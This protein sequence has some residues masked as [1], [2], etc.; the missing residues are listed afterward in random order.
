MAGYTPIDIELGDFSRTTNNLPLNTTNKL[1]NR[2]AK[3]KNWRRSHPYE[4]IL[5]EEANRE[6]NSEQ[7]D[8]QEETYQ[9]NPPVDEGFEE[10][11][12]D[13]IRPEPGEITDTIID[14]GDTAGLL[15]GGGAAGAAATG[16]EGVSG[17]ATGIATAALG[18]GS[19][20]VGGGVAAILN[21]ARQGKGYTLPNSEFIGPGNPIPIGAARNSADQ[22]AKKH[23]AGY[24]DLEDEPPAKRTKTFH[25]AV[26]DLDNEAIA[27][28]EESYKKD[29]SINAKLGATG[30]GIKRKVEDALG[31]PL[32]PKKPSKCIFIETVFIFVAGCLVHLVNLLM[33]DQIGATCTEEKDCMLIGNTTKLV[34]AEVLFRFLFQKVINP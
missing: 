14:I 13:Q 26:A 25:E 15:E 19:A 27:D 3:W 34:L 18:V 8:V 22:A 20:I 7:W 31:F 23:D 33:R 1:R 21:K 17:L 16:L 32:Y 4:E 5:D 2:F 9:E 12:L 28:F 29:G 6:I 30:L 10:I 24:R 11:E